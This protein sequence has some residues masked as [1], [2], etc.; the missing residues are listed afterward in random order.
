MV[1]AVKNLTINDIEYYESNIATAS[2]AQVNITSNP[3]K[4]THTSNGN[5]EQKLLSYQTIPV[6]PLPTNL[7]IDQGILEIRLMPQTLMK[8]VTKK[9][10][11]VVVLGDKWVNRGPRRVSRTD[12]DGI[13]PGNIGNNIVMIEPS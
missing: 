2:D 8:P 4:V 5:F 9:I 12:V 6:L 7:G 1:D 3:E 13:A 11:S 10:V